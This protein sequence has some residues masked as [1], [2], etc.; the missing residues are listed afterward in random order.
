VAL[1]GLAAAT[2]AFAAAVAPF[3]VMAW[4]TPAQ[5]LR[6]LRIFLHLVAARCWFLAVLIPVLRS[7]RL[8]R[9]RYYIQLNAQY[10][11]NAGY[12]E[13][14]SLAESCF[15]LA[16]C[17]SPR[18]QLISLTAYW[19]LWPVRALLWRMIRQPP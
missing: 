10:Y 2:A 13:A 5:H 14:M 19:G 12:G 3:L 11:V 9:Q 15:I 7:I 17:W 8:F 6:R 18:P 4:L 16:I 1:V